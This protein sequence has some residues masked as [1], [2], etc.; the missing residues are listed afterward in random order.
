MYTLFKTSALLMR[1]HMM[2]LVFILTS[3]ALQV[4][5]R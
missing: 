3:I 4:I 5:I 2:Y 1:F